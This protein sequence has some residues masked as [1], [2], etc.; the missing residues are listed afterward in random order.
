MIISSV[1][2]RLIGD[3]GRFFGA[4]GQLLVFESDLV[5]MVLDR[6][7]GRIN[8]QCPDATAWRR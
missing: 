5:Q 3:R 4:L 8:G 2:K 1:G 6:R 7:S